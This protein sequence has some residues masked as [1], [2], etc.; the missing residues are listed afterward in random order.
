MNV[1]KKVIEK[2][3]V[4]GKSYAKQVLHH[5]LV[6]HIFETYSTFAFEQMFYQFMQSHQMSVIDRLAP[7]GSSHE[8]RLMKVCDDSGIGMFSVREM[9]R[10]A[11]K[12]KMQVIIRLQEDLGYQVSCNCR[13]FW[14]FN[15]YCSH[16]FSVFNL[17]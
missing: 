7:K 11:V 10:G 16:I 15:L 8:H 3:I 12:D 2:T 5:P 1:E 17:L 13:Y 9:E 4:F 6:K 14:S